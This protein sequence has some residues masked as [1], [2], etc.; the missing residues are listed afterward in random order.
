MHFS[1]LSTVFTFLVQEG[2]PFYL[3]NS[4]SP[5]LQV[6]THTANSAMQNLNGINGGITHHLRWWTG[7]QLPWQMQLWTHTCFPFHLQSI[8]EWYKFILKLSNL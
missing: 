8:I 4:I 6:P 5:V 7:Y 1:Q 2:P 3:I